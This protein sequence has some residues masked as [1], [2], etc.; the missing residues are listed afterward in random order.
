MN[1]SVAKRGLICQFFMSYSLFPPPPSAQ[2]F[3][4]FV[5]KGHQPTTEAHLP[6]R[7]YK[8]PLEKL[9]RRS[10]AA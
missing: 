9:E 6:Q 2:V 3:N 4:T 8:T 10:L 1:Y 7:S 5:I